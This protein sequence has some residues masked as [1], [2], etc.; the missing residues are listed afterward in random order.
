MLYNRN[1]FVIGFMDQYQEYTPLLR[2]RGKLHGDF[3]P[4]LLPTDKIKHWKLVISARSAH[5]W[6]GYAANR[7]EFVKFCRYLS[8]NAP[9]SLKIWILPQGCSLDISRKQKSYHS[10]EEVLQALSILRNVGNVEIGEIPLIE[11]AGHQP[12]DFKTNQYPKHGISTHWVD[13]MK[14]LVRSNKPSVCVWKMYPRLASYAQSFERSEVYKDDLVPGWAK[15]EEYLDILECWA[16]SDDGWHWDE[17]RSDTPHNPFLCSPVHPVE[18]GLLLASAASEK[19]CLD[20]FLTARATVLSYLEPQY[21]RISAAAIQVCEFVKAYKRKGLLFSSEA[22]SFFLASFVAA[23]A[24]LLL[25]EYAR[26]SV[27]DVPFHTQV[28]ITRWKREFNSE[29]ETLEREKLLSKLN[30]VMESTRVN[31]T[32]FYQLFRDAVDNM[33]K[34]YL[35]IRAARKQLFEHDDGDYE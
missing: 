35:E 3:D 7:E 5:E 8:N 29:Y 21:Q 28:N 10:P 1:T 15:G 13:E 17:D 23:R 34:Q 2:H 4:S 14:D 24:L 16:P 19:N 32:N 11:L 27:R 30:K 6:E 26:S 33:D 22:E 20:Q 25:E 12:E 18:E 9:R 31:R